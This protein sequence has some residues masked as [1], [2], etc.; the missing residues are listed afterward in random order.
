LFQKIKKGDQIQV[1]LPSEV[2]ALWKSTLVE[3]ETYV[4]KNFK[5]HDNNF[6]VKYCVHPFKLLFVGGDGGSNI[7]Q[8]DI[9]DIPLYKFH[10]KPFPE[11]LNGQFRSDILVG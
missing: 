4:M 10:F 9:P 8:M 7:T 1:L 6:A 5:V 11:I 3:G 2:T